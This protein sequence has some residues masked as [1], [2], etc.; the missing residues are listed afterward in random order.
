MKGVII[1]TIMIL[2]VFFAS[3]SG[4][5]KHAK[6]SPGAISFISLDSHNEGFAIVTNQQLP[7]K[8]TI[9]FTDSEWNGNRFG[10][11]ESDIVW[12][13]GIDT[14]IPGTKIE[15]RNLDSVP[16]ASIGTVQNTLRLSKKEEAIFAYIGTTRMPVK[17]LAAAANDE[18]GYGTLINTG[19]HLGTT[20]ITLAKDTCITF[21]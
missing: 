6:L 11:D 5:K 8:T 10:E 18:S 2:M 21:Y 12:V 4:I 9:H 13:T 17:F 16:L 15:F 3:I 20:A 19:L 7:P 14:I 1:F